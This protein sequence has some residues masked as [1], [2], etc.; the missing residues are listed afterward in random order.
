MRE[1]S[2]VSPLRIGVMFFFCAFCCTVWVLG[3]VLPCC[4]VC[5]P[6]VAGRVLRWALAPML[7]NKTSRRRPKAEIETIHLF[8]CGNERGIVNIGV[9]QSKSGFE[10]VALCYAHV[11]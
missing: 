1:P 6:V 10:R 9:F 4:A 11:P 5:V 8:V 7:A 2:D 3:S